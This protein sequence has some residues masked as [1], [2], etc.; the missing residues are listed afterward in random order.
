MKVYVNNNAILVPHN[1]FPGGFASVYVFSRYE[2]SD[3]VFAVM[4]NLDLR[5]H[6]LDS[7]KCIGEI[8]KDVSMIVVETENYP[9]VM[10][11]RIRPQYNQLTA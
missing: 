4:T 2:N 8:G 11:K 10:L 9:K 5:P 3:G 1:E 7:L 6:K